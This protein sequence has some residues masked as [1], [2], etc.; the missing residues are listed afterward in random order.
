VDASVKD[1]VEVCGNVRGRP[2]DQA[3][4]FLE[5]A[6]GG[7][8]P[9]LY[10]SNNKRLGHRHELGGKKGRYP[11]KS[12]QIV[13]GVLRSALGNAQHKG[14]S[15]DLIVTHACANKVGKYMRYSP[16]GRRNPSVLRTARVEIVLK[17]REGAK[18]PAKKAQ[19]AEAPKA[20]PKGE[21][22]E[23]AKEAVMKEES[24]SK[25]EAVKA[26]MRAENAQIEEKREDKARAA[27]KGEKSLPGRK[28]PQK[29]K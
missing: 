12:A 29:V 21:Q 7:R 8:R 16:K 27:V 9:I 18:R 6:A 3:I 25:A 13:L 17:E 5:E 11:Q 19:K 14:L 20:P 24:A 22:K 10:R 15:E 2:V 1:L 26:E 23:A 28:P 4:K